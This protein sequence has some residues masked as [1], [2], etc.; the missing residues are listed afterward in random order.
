MTKY[1]INKMRARDLAIEWQ[2]RLDSPVQHS[3]QW[4]FEWQERFEKIAK[5]YGLTREFKE[6][7]II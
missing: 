3:W 6:N 5:K 4:C 7:G 1:K 2:A